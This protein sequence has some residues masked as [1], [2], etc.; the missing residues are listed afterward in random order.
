MYRILQPTIAIL[1]AFSAQAQN[2]NYSALLQAEGGKTY[3][4]SKAK[5]AADAKIDDKQGF[6]IFLVPPVYRTVIDTLVLSPALNGNLDTSNY[7]IQTEVIVLRDPGLEWRVANVS[8]LCMKDQSL[9]PQTALCLLKTAPKYDMINRKFFP[10][11]NILDTSRTDNVV[12]AEIKI[13]EREE[14]VMPAYLQKAN[15]DAV[16]PQGVRSIKIPAGQWT[17]W[18]EVVCP[19]GVFNDPDI[20]QVQEQL[21]KRGYDI[22]ITNSYDEQTKRALHQFQNDNVLA[23]GELDDKT[24]KR[25]GIEPEILIRV[26]D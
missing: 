12:P 3:S 21:Q 9:P 20:R 17:D 22:I 4:I 8:R 1:L 25:L 11:K 24:L 7:F 15:L 14:L 19:Y 26:E 2:S 13:V 16:P 6:Q 5:T 10:F 18:A 23:P